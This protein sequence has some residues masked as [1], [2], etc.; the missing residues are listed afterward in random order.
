MDLIASITVFDILGTISLGIVAA[1]LMKTFF[2]NN[3]VA[4]A[5]LNSTLVVLKNTEVVWRPVVNVSLVVLKPVL[6]FALM[7]FIQA[8]K[9]ISVVILS[10]LQIGQVCFNT[11]QA[12][13]GNLTQAAQ[14]LFVGT[15]DFLGSLATVMKGI[16][17]VFLEMVHWGS[18]VIRSFEQTGLFLRRF[19]F[20]GHRVTLDDLYNISVPFLVVGSILAFFYWRTFRTC[21]KPSAPE[22]KNDDIVVPRRSSRLA[23]KRAMMYCQDLATPSLTSQEAPL[24]ANL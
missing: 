18:F 6:K 20:E 22:K 2:A 23:R 19:L 17:Y 7:V 12:M 21:V 4:Q 14:N 8:S 15:K 3:P 9:A 1:T 24:A 11:L 13:G 5:F 16:G 10:A